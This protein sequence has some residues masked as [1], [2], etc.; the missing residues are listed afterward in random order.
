MWSI[1]C[2]LS[3]MQN[4]YNCCFSTNRLARDFVTLKVSNL[5][6]KVNVVLS[7]KTFC[8]TLFFRHNWIV[9]RAFLSNLSHS[10]LSMS[11]G[12]FYIRIFSRSHCIKIAIIQTCHSL[13]FVMPSNLS[14]S[15]LIIVIFEQVGYGNRTSS[16]TSLLR[17]DPIK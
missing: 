9:D 12:I 17:I 5:F 2:L 7:I 14:I 10:D 15:N 4:M 13:K 16:D 1:R 8:N 11:V 6:D 3:L